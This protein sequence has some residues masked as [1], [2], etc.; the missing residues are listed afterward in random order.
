MGT[1]LFPKDN[2]LYRAVDEVLHY[3]WDP[4][5][6]SGIPEAR[7]EYHNYLP[8]IFRLLKDEAGP[9]TIAKHLFEITTDRMGLDGNHQRDAEVASI[10][11]NWKEVIEARLA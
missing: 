7:D 2:D 11:T 5:G 4:I 6:V 3:L 10:L 9:E 1:Q 8:M